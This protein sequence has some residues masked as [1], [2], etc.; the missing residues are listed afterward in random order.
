MKYKY[1]VWLGGNC[2]GG[3][4]STRSGPGTNPW[5]LLML[6]GVG[7]GASASEMAQHWL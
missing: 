7:V 2:A 6:G 5:R 1:D 4:L 3:D